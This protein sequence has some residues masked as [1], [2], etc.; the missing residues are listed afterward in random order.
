M[1]TTGADRLTSL[2][3]DKG[4]P[5]KDAPAKKGFSAKQLV[6]GLLFGIIFG[7]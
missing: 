7:F 5:E 4:G 3:I 1:T 2:P 6:L